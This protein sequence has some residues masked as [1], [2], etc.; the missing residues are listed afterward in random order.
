MNIFAVTSD[1]LLGTDEIV[2]FVDNENNHK[3]VTM[4]KEEV[5][6]INELK[7]NKMVY[8]ILIPDTKRGMEIIKGKIG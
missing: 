7:K 3:H 8:D 5:A 6:F 2:T 1:Y 4:T